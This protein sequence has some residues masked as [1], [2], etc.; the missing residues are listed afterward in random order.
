MRAFEKATKDKEELL[1]RL[2]I[3]TMSEMKEREMRERRKRKQIINQVK[4]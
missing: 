4:I 2:R 3:Q 1:E